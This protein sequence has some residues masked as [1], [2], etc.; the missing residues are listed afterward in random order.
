MADQVH[1]QEMERKKVLGI[2]ANLVLV[3]NLN[4]PDLQIIQNTSERKSM[5]IHPIIQ[6]KK[7]LVLMEK[8]SLKAEVTDLKVSLSKNIV[9][10][11]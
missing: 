10:K 3:I 1:H 4:Q 11:E 9:K 5:K 6:K 8:K 2:K 7:A